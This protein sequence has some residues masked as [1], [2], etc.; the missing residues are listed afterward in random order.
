MLYNDEELATALAKF[1]T[2]HKLPAG[3]TTHKQLLRSSA[4]IGT[5]VKMSFP[6]L[7]AVAATAATNVQSAAR[8]RA[9]IKVKMALEAEREESWGEEYEDADEDED[10]DEDG[11][12]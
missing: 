10:E 6:A 5:W 4:R 8:R 1:E 12:L 11:D 3:S 9:A 7:E 2:F